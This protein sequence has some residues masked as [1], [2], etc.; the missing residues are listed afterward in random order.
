MGLLLR[1]FWAV[2][3]AAAAAA[4]IAYLASR[5][6]IAP[7]YEAA[8]QITVIAGDTLDDCAAAA[9][10]RQVLEQVIDSLGLGYSYED[11]SDMVAAK[12]FAASQQVT[13]TVAH[14]S[15][16][17][18]RDLANAIGETA[19]AYVAETAGAGAA[20]VTEYAKTPSNPSSPDIKLNTAL[21]GAAGLVLAMAVAL[22][23]CILDDSIRTGEDVRYH[24]NLD[25]LAVVPREGSDRKGGIIE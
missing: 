9:G 11:L 19:S 17:M 21:G 3:L 10:S 20:K 13:V 1:R 2:L 23:V 14:A 22:M 5:F 25:V 24:L 18:A 7:T 4:A 12:A 6:L 16:T 15:P 8:A